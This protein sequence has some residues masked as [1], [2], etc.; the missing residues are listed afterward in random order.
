MK[1][2]LSR[3]G[4]TA[5]YDGAAAA[6][7]GAA[8]A[9]AVTA[10]IR[11]TQPQVELEAWAE[12][13]KTPQ[14]GLVGQLRCPERKDFFPYFRWCSWQL[15]NNGLDGPQ[16]EVDVGVRGFYSLVPSEVASQ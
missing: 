5:A 4:A 14:E 7:A 12:L 16:S 3:V 13:G 1:Y 8:V 10:K 11:L 2:K 6:Y 9:Y 15:P